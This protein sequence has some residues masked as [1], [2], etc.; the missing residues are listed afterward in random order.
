M[1]R[2]YSEK[3]VASIMKAAARESAQTGQ[4]EPGEGLSLD[5]LEAI[6]REHDIDPAA[7]RRAAAR[8]DRV[9]E[10]PR[11]GAY[12]GVK[13]DVRHVVTLSGPVSDATFAAIADDCRRIFGARGH[14]R[15]D[16]SSWEWHNGNL[17]IVLE[18]DPDDEGYQ[19]HMSSRLGAARSMAPASLFTVVMA[20]FVFLAGTL[21]GEPDIVPISVLMTVVAAALYGTAHLSTRSWSAERRAQMTEIGQRAQQ[22]QRTAP[23]SELAAETESSPLLDGPLSGQDA[24]FDPENTP[25]SRTRTR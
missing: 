17:R 14:V 10:A 12:L 7:I 19:L 20:V 9:R 11:S 1:T 15:S 6:G 2:Q 3:E 24:H 25:A 4:R 8:L 22:R 13:T 23:T 18:P 5:E 16:S 21:T